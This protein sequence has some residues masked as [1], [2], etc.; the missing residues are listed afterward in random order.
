MMKA[1]ENQIQ[2]V[3]TQARPNHVRNFPVF[4][5]SKPVCWAPATTSDAAY[6]SINVITAMR[7]HRLVQLPFT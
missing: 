2:A 4:N 5:N 7:L 1:Y 6:M 3:V